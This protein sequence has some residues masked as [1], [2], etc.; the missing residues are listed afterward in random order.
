M[1]FQAGDS[2]GGR[3]LAAKY[4]DVVFSANTAY[5]KAL[6]YAEDL[7]ARLTRHGRSADAVRILPGATVVLGEG[8]E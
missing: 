1:L 5:G 4:A 2:P 6:A 3:E 7:R 8:L